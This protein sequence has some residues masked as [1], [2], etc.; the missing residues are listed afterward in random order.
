ML[1]GFGGFVGFDCMFRLAIVF[2]GFG[3]CGLVWWFCFGFVGWVWFGF[4]V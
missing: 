2:L 3:V 4:I 1:L